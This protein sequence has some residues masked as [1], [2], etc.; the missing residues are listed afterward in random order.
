MDTTHGSALAREFEKL[1]VVEPLADAIGTVHVPA[2]R[3]S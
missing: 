1:I 2:G 3:A